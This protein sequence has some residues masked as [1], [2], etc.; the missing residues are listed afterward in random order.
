MKRID[1]HGK[2][3]ERTMEERAMAGLYAYCAQETRKEKRRMKGRRSA[4]NRNMRYAG[5]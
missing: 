5:H 1:L 2:D 3:I 4:P